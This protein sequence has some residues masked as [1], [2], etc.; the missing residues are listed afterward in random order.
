MVSLQ[1]SLGLLVSN[2]DGD[3]L[4]L[5][6][7]VGLLEP[8]SLVGEGHGAWHSLERVGVGSWGLESQSSSSFSAHD[9]LV[10][11][12]VLVIVAVGVIDKLESGTAF[13]L[14]V[15]SVAP[16]SVLNGG[17]S[18]GVAHWELKGAGRLEST[19]EHVEVDQ[20]VSGA[21][22]GEESG[23]GSELHFIFLLL[24]IIISNGLLIN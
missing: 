13:V 4:D 20:G 21:G 15:P 6:I 14:D 12:H 10:I 19:L 3:L 18:D 8:W 2:D 16:G 24:I 17:D 1:S 9:E 5:V 11:S 7:R 22:G 23:E